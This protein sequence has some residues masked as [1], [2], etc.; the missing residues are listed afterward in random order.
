MPQHGDNASNLLDVRKNNINVAGL[1]FLAD[2]S[3]A[4]VQVNEKKYHSSAQALEMVRK[5]IR[6]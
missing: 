4:C 3:D 6:R 5:K 1:E 2:I